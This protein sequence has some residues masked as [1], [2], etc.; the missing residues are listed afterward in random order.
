M[1]PE[2]KLRFSVNHI[3][4]E[5]HSA[6]WGND[7]RR[8]GGN[9]MIN[10]QHSC[11]FNPV[12]NEGIVSGT[13]VGYVDEE[14]NFVEKPVITFHNQYNQ[15][16]EVFLIQCHIYDGDYGHSHYSHNLLVKVKEVNGFLQPVIIKE[17]LT[18]SL[19]TLKNEDYNW[20]QPGKYY[21]GPYKR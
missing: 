18:G 1:K 10:G 17:F 13:S 4:C 19:A 14:K 8:Y 20:S 21:A 12:T 9:I 2:T 6:R 3:T 5:G 11:S 7:P 16:K 15:E